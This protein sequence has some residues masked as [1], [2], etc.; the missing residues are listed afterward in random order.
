MV[1]NQHSHSPLFIYK[2]KIKK[3]KIIEIRLDFRGQLMVLSF[4]FDEVLGLKWLKDKH[5]LS[6]I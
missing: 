5:A 2:F 1:R 6:Q 3:K 4:F